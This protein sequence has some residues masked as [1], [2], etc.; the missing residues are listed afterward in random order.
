MAELYVV[1]VVAGPET[2]L[3]DDKDEATEPVLEDTGVVITLEEA[4]EDIL[5]TEEEEE[6]EASVDT[7]V[8]LVSTGVA[9]VSTEVA[10]GVV[11]VSGWVIASVVVTG[12][13]PPVSGETA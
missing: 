10:L 7:A 6:E 8:V 2:E 12:T 13:R 5:S 4:E 3:E 9:V 11:L 1:K